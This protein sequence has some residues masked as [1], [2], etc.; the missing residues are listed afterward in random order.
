MKTVD[1]KISFNSRSHRIELFVRIIWGLV[2]GIVLG[3]FGFAAAII[4]VLQLLHILITGHRHKG[5]Q[6]FIKTVAIQHFRLSAYLSLLTDER[7]PII[8]ESMP[9]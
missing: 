7:P 4:W 5:M 1:A 9:A 6:S 2:A 3:I 8:P